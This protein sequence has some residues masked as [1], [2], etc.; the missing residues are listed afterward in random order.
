MRAHGS[1]LRRVSTRL[2][3]ST[4]AAESHGSVLW[5]PTQEQIE[6]SE[7]FRF[8]RAIAPKH[9]YTSS[10]EGVD[11]HDL[12]RW[13]VRD[14]PSFH[15]ALWD[16]LDIRHSA[17]Y[18]APFV[19]G[20][21]G[22]ATLADTFATARFYPGA[23][24]NFAENVLRFADDARRSND[25]ARMGKDAFLW[26]SE[27]RPLES[28]RRVSY[29]SLRRQVADLARQLRDMGVE[30]GDSVVGFLPHSPD[31]AIA[32]LA[33]TSIGA[34]WSSCS[35]DFG[36]GGAVDRFGQ[37]SPKVLFAVAEYYHKGKR[38]CLRERLSSIHAKLPSAPKTILFDYDADAASDAAPGA[39]AALPRGSAV[40][41]RELALGRGPGSE[42]VMEYEMV[43]VEHPVYTMFSSG[44]T[45]LP[46]CMSQGF[47]VYVTHMKEHLLHHGLRADDVYLQ[48]T[49]TGWMMW[50]Y[51]L[52]A[53]A[54]GAT[55]VAYEGDPMT[56]T[57][58]M[59][60]DVCEGAGVTAL[61]LSARFLAE[62][63]A[64]GVVPAESHDLS[65]LRLVTSTGSPA[66]GNV[67]GY[68]SHG[69]KRGGVQF[70]SVSG[71]TDLN[72]CFACGN[73]L[74][75]V[76]EGELQCRA[77]GMDVAILTDDGEDVPDGGGRGEL[78]CRQPF[79]SQ[80][81]SFGGEDGDEKYFDAYFA[82]FPGVWRHGDFA[83]VKKSGGV[84]IHGR[85]D[86]TLNPGGVRIGT[87][88]IY[89]VVEKDL[90]EEIEDSVVVGRPFV[91]P[92]GT[93][94]VEIVLFAK[95]RD[96]VTM[97]D[98]LVQKVRATI[99]RE[100]SPRHA[101]RRVIQAPD[102]PV[103]TNGKK[104]EIAVL[105]AMLGQQVKNKGALANPQSLAFFENL[106]I[107]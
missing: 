60:F 104:A 20:G 22:G 58:T 73:P 25:A 14:V 46:K 80:P 52:S 2:L 64:R 6:G 99:R 66:S 8:A 38:V 30:R 21:S 32:A 95:L 91:L 57:A 33:A 35:P 12:W 90:S 79:A 34:V 81:I 31:A 5:A 72:G 92:D 15:A 44:T 86:T 50:N 105:R 23:R 29:E 63:D 16:Y 51:K 98:D 65:R 4:K 97:G 78:C 62:A 96:G 67:F 71:G 83:E 75:P 59:L 7:M 10:S 47:G 93:P 87:A 53:L 48:F 40:L 101:P 76:I 1:A 82:E 102:F 36:E 26:Y 55:L 106:V 9:G 17:P 24:V 85:S 11:Y 84:V 107:E 19:P 100:A 27:A 28:P 61:G 74:L 68:A 89:A 18:D 39:A 77:L 42:G 37:V 88:D 54:T 49:T 3:S 56:P 41:A 69:L 103:T 43:P 45:G 70:C 94:D 13:S